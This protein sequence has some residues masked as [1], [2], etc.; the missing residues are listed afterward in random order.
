MDF[1]RSRIS[2]VWAIRALAVSGTEPDDAGHHLCVSGCDHS[3]PFGLGHLR[4]DGLDAAIRQ[5]QH[6][7]GEAGQGFRDPHR[8]QWPGESFLSR[9]MYADPHDE[10]GP[11]QRGFF[12]FFPG[13]VRVL[14]AGFGACFMHQRFPEFDLRWT[15]KPQTSK[16]TSP[17]LRA[18]CSA[19]TTAGHPG[20]GLN[21]ARHEARGQRPEVEVTGLPNC[22]KGLLAWLLPYLQVRGSKQGFT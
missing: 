11:F 17:A 15:Q 13:R 5:G 9:P 1:V 21:R 22:P 12:L 16:R 3:E 2:F 7:A 14:S 20:P 6:Q 18:M 10:A 19:S 4:R 8:D